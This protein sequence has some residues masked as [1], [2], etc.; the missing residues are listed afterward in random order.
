MEEYLL[1]AT[2][3]KTKELTGSEII[4]DTFL[5]KRV[6]NILISSY[7]EIESQL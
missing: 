7:Q 4:E 1:L 2:G 3:D 6:T 5:L